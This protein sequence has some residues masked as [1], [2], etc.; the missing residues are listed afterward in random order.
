MIHIALSSITDRCY[1][2]R[3]FTANL[4]KTLCSW[5]KSKEKMLS[6][7]WVEDCARLCHKATKMLEK[8]PAASVCQNICDLNSVF[9]PWLVGTETTKSNF[10]LH[11]HHSSTYVIFFKMLLDWVVPP[12]K[13]QKSY[14][15]LLHLFAE[16]VAK[17]SSIEEA[18][19]N[20]HPNPFPWL[21]R[22]TRCY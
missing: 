12:F 19:C 22:T 16:M 6:K 5:P 20:C 13:C 11:Q 14:C 10:L 21:D 18:S 8:V 1:V 4:H 7:P 17:G 2:Y 15:N 3:F 9:C